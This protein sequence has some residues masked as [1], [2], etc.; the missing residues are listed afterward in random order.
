M[1]EP[2]GQRRNS[3]EVKVHFYTRSSEKFNERNI[4][5]YLDPDYLQNCNKITKELF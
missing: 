1:K 2:F 3:A 5:C 4:K